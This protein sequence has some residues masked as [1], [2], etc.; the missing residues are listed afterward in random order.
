MGSF[1]LSLDKT[2]SRK[3]E[4]LRDKCYPTMTVDDAVK[5]FVK[6][7]LNAKVSDEDVIAGGKA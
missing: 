4:I 6:D 7:S 1:T 2:Y 3:A 5:E